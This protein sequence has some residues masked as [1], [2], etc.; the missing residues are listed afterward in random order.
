MGGV[1]VQDIDTD[2]AT[3]KPYLDMKSTLGDAF[4][5]K[6]TRLYRNKTYIATSCSDAFDAIMRAGGVLREE[7]SGYRVGG[8]SFN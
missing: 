5:S 8:N 6:G 4:W 1:P 2:V 3:E 7:Q